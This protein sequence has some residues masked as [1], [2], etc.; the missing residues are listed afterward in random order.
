MFLKASVGF[1]TA[2]NL[3]FTF[4]NI[5]AILKEKK[6]MVNMEI[7]SDELFRGTA[8]DGYFFQ[9]TDKRKL[10]DIVHAHTFYEIFYILTGS[11]THEKNNV[12]Q[13]LCAGDMILLQPEDSHRFLSQ[14]AD[15]DILALSV[16]KTEMEK[17]MFS[18]GIENI[19]SLPQK[20]SLSIEQK[21]FFT[22]QSDMFLTHACRNFRLLVNQMML[23][24]VFASHKKESLPHELKDAI[25][26]MSHME[27]AAK[28]VQAFLKFSGYSHSQLC[29]LTEKHFGVTPTEYVNKIR[30]KHA[31]ALVTGTDSDY[32][33]ICEQ[34]G[35]ESYSYFC[36]LMKKHYGISVAKLRKDRHGSQQTI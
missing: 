29:R 33:S 3:F 16:S 11:C 32:E 10:S 12:L 14:S 25:E 1:F 8:S 2:K 22:A 35:F 31:Y 18:C 28:G 27:N 13:K 20:I 30:M 5:S 23:L 15:T 36:K 6:E 17:I 7:Y 26:K 19:S 21:I 9:H 34:V 24:A 4:R